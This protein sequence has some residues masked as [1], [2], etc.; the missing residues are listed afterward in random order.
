MVKSGWRL[1]EFVWWVVGF[2]VVAPVLLLVAPV[3]LLMLVAEW[4]FGWMEVEG[5]GSGR[6]GERG[7]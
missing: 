4:A 3:L 6:K 7:E 1:S 2:V 5:P